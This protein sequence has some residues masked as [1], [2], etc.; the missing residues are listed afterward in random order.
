M[1]SKKKNF[2]VISKYSVNTG[3]LHATKDAAVKAAKKE[4]IADAGE[5]FGDSKFY[6]VEILG[7]VDCPAPPKPVAA[8]VTFEER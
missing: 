4:A 3:S 8:D 6:V 5:W 1:S 7:E 2:A